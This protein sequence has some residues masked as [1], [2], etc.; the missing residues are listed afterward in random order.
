MSLKNDYLIS[1]RKSGAIRILNPKIKPWRLRSGG[2][3]RIYIDHAKISSESEYYITFLNAINEL[4]PKN[5]SFIFCN[6]DSKIS[7]QMTG[8][9]SYLL[10]KSQIIFKSDELTRLEKGPMQ[11]FTIPKKIFDEVFIIDDV[12]TSGGTVINVVKLLRKKLISKIKVTLFVGLV[13]E[14]QILIKN[15]KKNKIELKYLA[16]LDE[17]LLYNWDLFTENEREVITQERR[18]NNLQATTL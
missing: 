4:I 12:G 3:S 9:M 15:L 2:L 8:T 16:T 1:L 10:K 5:K 14:P 6:V 11:Q 13:R 7:A 18:I 17:L